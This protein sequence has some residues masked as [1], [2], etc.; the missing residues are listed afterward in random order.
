MNIGL[1]MMGGDFAPEQ[2]LLGVQQFLESEYGSASDSVVYALGDES[3]LKPHL[4]NYI[5]K[6]R[7]VIVHA[8]ELIAMNE[9]PTKALKEKPNSAI[10]IGFG[11][12]ALGKL[13]AF[14]S[15]GNTGTMLVGAAHI[16]KPI[17]GVQRPTIP[18]YVPKLNGG[19]SLLLDVGINADCKPENLEQFAMLASVYANN[20]L[21]IDNPKVALLNIGEEEGKGNLLAKAAYDLLKV[22]EHI[23][24]T[25]NA[26]GRDIFTGKADVIVCDGFT[27][28]IVL[29][30]AESM[31][32][33][34]CHKRKL[35]D[36]Y[37]DS[38]NYEN[39][40]G[41]PVLGVNKTVIVGHGISSATAFSNMIKQADEIASSG[42]LQQ[43]K[44]KFQQA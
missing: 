2:S 42:M 6:G 16:I 43:L 38:F 15:A 1:D 12:L 30:M 5:D 11:M 34:F 37:L 18:T 39:Y 25:G 13:D 21:K 27:G 20:V 41:T 36:E 29:K 40:G 32:E 24:F 4:Q 22:N 26:E 9:H 19:Y 10:A 17:A 3:V 8:P 23:N 7:V 28:N 35:Q 14:I 44:D 31:Y 33:I